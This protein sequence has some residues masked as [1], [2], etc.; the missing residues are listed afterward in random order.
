MGTVEPNRPGHLDRLE[1]YFKELKMTGLKLYPWDATSQGGW[2]CNDENLAYPL[3]QKCLE[4]GIDKI[5]IHKGIPA[6]FTMAKYVH[7]LDLDQP[8][9]DFP[10]LNIIVYHAGFPYIDDLTG[11][12]TG[13]PPFPNLYVDV[14]STFALLVN[15]PSRWRTTWASCCVG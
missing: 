12:N 13:R 10:N 11:L 7:P 15:T 9:R 4:L 5:H 3:W 2:W 8:L 14:G 6:S 1:Y